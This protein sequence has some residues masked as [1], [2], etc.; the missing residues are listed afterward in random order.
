M[1][2]LEVGI[3]YQTQAMHNDH[4]CRFNIL[5]EGLSGWQSSNRLIKS[6]RYLSIHYVNFSRNVGRSPE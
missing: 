1:H 5:I 4:C 3:T 6:L 2:Q